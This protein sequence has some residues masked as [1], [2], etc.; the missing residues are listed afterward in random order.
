[1]SHL[2]IRSTDPNWEKANLRSTR[3]KDEAGKEVLTFKQITF[4]TMR[5]DADALYKIGEEQVKFEKGH[6][7][8]QTSLDLRWEEREYCRNQLYGTVTLLLCLSQLP[9]FEFSAVFPYII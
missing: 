5:V 9:Q 2:S 6:L 7:Q 8:L 3:I 1:M 4:G